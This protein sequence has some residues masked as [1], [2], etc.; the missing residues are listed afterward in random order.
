MKVSEIDTGP[1]VT[2][3][4]LDLEPGPA[5]LESDGSG[6]R[7][8]DCAAGSSRANSFSNSRKNTVVSKFPNE[9]RVMVRMKELIEA[10]AEENAEMRLPLFLGKDVSGRAMTVDLAKMPHLLIAGRTGTG[11]SVCLNTLILSLLRPA[12]RSRS[13]C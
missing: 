6:R 1:V 2:Q 12:A 5:R 8:G 13:R 3:F 10:S 9:K 7:S 4:E 11:K